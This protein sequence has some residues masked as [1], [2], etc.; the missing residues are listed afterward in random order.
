M[1]SHN[2]SQE[3][4]LDLH[5]VTWNNTDYMEDSISNFEELQESVADLGIHL[6][7]EFSDVHNRSIMADN[8]WRISLGRGLDIFDRI[9][10]KFNVADLDQEK[11]KCK[12]CN[13]IYFK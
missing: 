9:E 2:K 5:M 3:E 13:I 7:Y 12:A 11:R 6:T 10:G 8:G 1:L 4:E